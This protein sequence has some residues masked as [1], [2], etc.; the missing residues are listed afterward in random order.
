MLRESLSREEIESSP[1]YSRLK[2]SEDVRDNPR[3][4]VLTWI[5]PEKEVQDMPRVC[6]IWEIYTKQRLLKRCSTG[7]VKNAQE[8]QIQHMPSYYAWISDDHSHFYLKDV[9]TTPTLDELLVHLRL[10]PSFSLLH[11][12]KKSLVYEFMDGGLV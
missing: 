11:I 6:E 10:D 4:G 12:D 9:L 8:E 7:E 5:Q 1:Q 2:S 3:F